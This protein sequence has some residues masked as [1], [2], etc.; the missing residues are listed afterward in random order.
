[1]M[2]VVPGITQT[3]VIVNKLE[4][5]TALD[6]TTF[7]NTTTTTVLEKRCEEWTEAQHAVFQLA[8][9]CMLISFLTPCTFRYHTFFLRILLNFGY[10]LTLI[11][12][13]VFVCMMDVVIWSSIIITVNTAYILYL[14]YKY[15]PHRFSKALDEVY[16]HTYKPLK[17][18]RKQFK[19]I[20][21][22]GTMQLLGKGSFYARQDHTPT[23]HRLA[24][25][26]KGRSV[27]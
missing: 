19:G 8:K 2:D 6:N 4:T 25:L 27:T 26:L 13:S 18:S 7:I 15:I 3:E 9:L 14:G 20:A 1:M 17:V 21:N 5:Q 10:I 23:G 16:L 12:A 11:W 22:L 24:I